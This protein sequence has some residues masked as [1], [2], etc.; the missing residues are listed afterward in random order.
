MSS[1]LSKKEDLKKTFGI[2]S[3]AASAQTE[4]ISSHALVK[5]QDT[6]ATVYATDGDRMAY[7]NFTPAEADGTF[8]FTV[9]PK[10][11]LE[12]INSTDTDSIKITYDQEA[13]TVSVYDSENSESVL[14]FPS[15]NSEEFLTFDSE[16]GKAIPMGSVDSEMLQMGLKFIQGFLPVE[17]N[18]KSEKY[19]RLYASKGVLYGANGANKI[20]AF[21]SN[22]LTPLDEL[23]IRRNMLE[24]IA[25]KKGLLEQSGSSKISIITTS[26]MVFLT[27][28]DNSCGFGFL[29]T[30]DAIP[31][32]PISID[33]PQC[34]GF[35]ISRPGLIK[36]LDRLAITSANGIKASV[37]NE[38][39][40]MATVT[41]RVSKDSIACKILRGT[42]KFEYTF[43]HKLMGSILGLFQASN[44]DIYIDKTKC[45]LISQ[46]ELEDITTK[47]R[48][49]FKAIG[50][51]SLARAV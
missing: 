42:E 19:T 41:E 34:N 47:E 49:P 37:E 40:S 2:V 38:I 1:I 32:Y 4:K 14:S 39:L 46:A 16:M 50:L 11:M 21:Q 8:E 12:V 33:N 45:L 28:S 5:I 18:P 15:F 36:K 30:N 44:L 31:K 43:D 22:E 24:P 51:M 29:R 9:D 27:S 35:N 7:S 25:G 3:L 10:K 6:K 26:N 17:K 48:K 23:I 13:K 20:G